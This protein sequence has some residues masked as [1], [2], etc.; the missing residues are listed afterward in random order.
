VTD[1]ATKAGPSLLQRITASG[2]P[3]EAQPF[4]RGSARGGRLV[5]LI[6]EAQSGEIAFEG[7]SLRMSLTPAMIL[8]DVD[9]ALA[10]RQLA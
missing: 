5:R 2:L 3:Y 1:A 7:G 8:F 6:E 10:P 4:R 9:G